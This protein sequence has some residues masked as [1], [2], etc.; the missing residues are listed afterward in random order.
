MFS[1]WR[2]SPEPLQARRRGRDS[3]RQHN[4]KGIMTQTAELANE[5]VNELATA[6]SKFGK[7]NSA[8]EGYAVILEEVDELKEEI[9]KKR[10]DR[11]KGAMRAECIQIA[12]MALRFIE[13]VC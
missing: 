13:D 7:F 6:G 2:A 9:W 5:V 3:L 10:K 12:A 4:R 8:H 1:C 11:D